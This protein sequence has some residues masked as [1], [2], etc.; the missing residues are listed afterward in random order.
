MGDGWLDLNPTTR[1]AVSVRIPMGL[2]L[3]PAI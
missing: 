2:D 3:N 1:L